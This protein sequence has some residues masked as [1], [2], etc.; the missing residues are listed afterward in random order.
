M[1]KYCVVV[2]LLFLVSASYQGLMYADEEQA[3]G[4]WSSSAGLGFT[5]TGGNSDV[6]NLALTFQVVQDL[7]TRKWGSYANMTV[8]TT[9]GDKTANRGSLKSQYDFFPTDRFFYFGKVGIE[10]DKFTDLDL[11][12]SPGAG[13][14]YVVVQSDVSRLSASAGSNAVT[15][16]FSDG[17]S[18]TKG[19]LS[20]SEELSL[21]ITSAAALYQN[22]NVQSNFEDFGD[23][24]LE[25]ELSL[26]AKV[27]DQVSMKAS[28]LDKYDSDPFSDL[29]EKNDITFITSIN[30]TM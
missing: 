21:N 24:L 23:Y 5:A 7:G 15:D 1:K 26:S 12:T 29:L 13:I 19:V 22:I 30:V 3:S 11:R 25:A 4:P 18:E 20:M 16:K 27:S 17:N 14:G 10:Y 8:S 9:D 2:L 6:T 28:L